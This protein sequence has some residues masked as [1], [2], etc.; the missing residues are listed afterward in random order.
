MGNKVLGRGK[1]ISARGRLKILL[2]SSAY[3]LRT[4]ACS[5]IPIRLDNECSQGDRN[6]LP[7]A[8]SEM[9]NLRSSTFSYQGSHSKPGVD[10]R[11]IFHNSSDRPR[12][13]ITRK[14]SDCI[15]VNGMKLALCQMDRSDI[16]ALANPSTQEIFININSEVIRKISAQEEKVQR[17]L[18]LEEIS[19]ELAHLLGY[20][21]EF[22]DLSFF[23]VQRV[24]KYIAMQSM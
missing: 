19:H 16:N 11:R 4:M 10:G 18:L 3:V 7:D 8:G 24:L 1:T 20:G 21:L 14:D 2:K 13:I 22:H 17:A 6:Y 5:N 9:L 15:S 23:K 12:Y